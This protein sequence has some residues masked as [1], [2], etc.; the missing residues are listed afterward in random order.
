M[1]NRERKIE[2]H[3][4]PSEFCNLCLSLCPEETIL[5]IS[6][7]KTIT[8]ESCIVPI[9]IPDISTDS[10][11]VEHKLEVVVKLVI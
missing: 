9:L 10:N 7:V 8:N 6:S 5:W 3:L 1:I 2:I 4:I 11:S